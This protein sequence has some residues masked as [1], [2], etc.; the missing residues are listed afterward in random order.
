MRNI[1]IYNLPKELDEIKARPLW[2]CYKLQPRPTKDDPGHLGKIPYNPKTGNGADAAN[3]KTWASYEEAAAGV[4][5]GKYN[6]IGFEFGAE[7]YAGIDIDNCIDDDGNINP[8]AEYIINLLDSYT[9]LSISGHGTHTI[10]KSAPLQAAGFSKIPQENKHAGKID[11][12]IYRPREAT[13]ARFFGEVEGGRYFTISGNVYGDPKPINERTEILKK[14]VKEYFTRPELPT[15]APSVGSYQTTDEATERKIIE[16]ALDAIDPEDLDFEQWAAI[17]SA[18]KATGFSV[19]EAEAWSRK[20]GNSK[21]IP[22]TIARRWNKLHLKNHDNENAAGVIIKT[23]QGYG[24]QVSEAFTE[25]ERKEYGRLMHKDDAK[26]INKTPQNETKE[27]KANEAPSGSP[28]G[29][30]DAQEGEKPNESIIKFVNVGE[31]LQ[32]GQYDADLAY[33]EKYRDRKTG[34]KQID[35]YLTLYPGVAILS[36]ATSLG[37]TSFCVQLADMLIERGETVLYFSLEQLPI[38]L[39]SKSISRRYFELS[40]KFKKLDL[41][42]I[43]IRNGKGGD[44]PAIIEAR[45]QQA[46]A[47]KHFY[48]I[49]CD[50]SITADQIAQIVETFIKETDIKPVVIIDYMQ[51]I[52]APEGARLEDRGRIDDIM[53]RIKRLSKQQQLFVLML[54]NIA[55]GKYNEKAA[56]D[57]FKESGGIEYGADY[58]FALQLSVIESNGFR[59]K[60]GSKGGQLA[61]TDEEKRDI[62]NKQYAETTRDIV[63]KAFKNRNGKKYFD[64]YFKY[65]VEYDYFEEAPGDRQNYTGEPTEKKDGITWE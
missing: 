57:G 52:S 56:E 42:N 39:I 24:F 20:H 7:G 45:K 25:E 15:V 40:D 46:E 58:L 22:G 54:S 38:E 50:F 31:H 19:D 32:S 11:L 47:G 4:Q 44:D 60:I 2:V 41:T 28:A 53:K 64:A 23:A 63:F 10:V 62:I 8:E 21:H 51:I 18:M 43:D 16:A 34:F 3:P 35:R 61:R 27:T 5:S 17:I 33:F 6:G 29:A 12:E 36:G 65:N 13:D 1:N 49:E 30:T 55:R 9:E 48:I 14:I 37:K 59:Y 26:T